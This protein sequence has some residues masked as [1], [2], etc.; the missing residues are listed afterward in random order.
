MPTRSSRWCG[1]TANDVPN[2]GGGGRE[3]FPCA[4]RCAVAIRAKL[5]APQVRELLFDLCFGGSVSGRRGLDHAVI[6]GVLA[7]STRGLHIS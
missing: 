3:S 4:G 1:E 6:E 5:A 7:Q 2:Q